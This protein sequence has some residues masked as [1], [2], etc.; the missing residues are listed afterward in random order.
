MRPKNIV[1]GLIELGKTLLAIRKLKLIISYLRLS[2]PNGVIDVLIALYF[3]KY[4]D[5]DSLIQCHF[6]DRKF[7][8]GNLIKELNGQNK[9]GL[10]VHAHELY[11][12]P[13][14]ELFKSCLLRADKI[15]AISQLN[16]KLLL[17]I[18]PEL[19]S[20]KIK[21]IYLS[22]DLDLFKANGN[23]TRILTVSRFTERKG[24][25][26]LFEAIKIL[27]NPNVEFICIG[28]GDL[29]LLEL[30]KEIRC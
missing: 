29:D 17:E 28:W 6:G 26:E 22:I 10:T 25:R 4:V 3:S 19:I 1:I 21:V 14:L 9:L 30:A 20:E 13:N 15:V 18:Q 5:N 27:S 12:N 2:G 23:V 11:A 8:V 7:F 16:K 24:F